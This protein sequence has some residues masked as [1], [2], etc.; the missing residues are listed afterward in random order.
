MADGTPTR[1]LIVDDNRVA[2]ETLAT[3]IRL[4]GHEVTTAYDGVTGVQTALSFRP[5]LILLD[6]VMPEVDGFAVARA[7]RSLM[8]PARIVAL[9]AFTQPAFMEAADDVGFDS[10]VAKPA[11]AEQLTKLLMH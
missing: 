3:L 1:V 9:T 2:A 10:I 5:E 8:L 11:T 7:L 6:L 4:L